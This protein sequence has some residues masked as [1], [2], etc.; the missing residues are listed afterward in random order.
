MV[1][2]VP[3][4]RPVL[5]VKAARE[6]REVP[7]AKGEPAAKGALVGE[8]APAAARVALAAAWDG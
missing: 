3:R 8:V 4:V 7:E 1:K 5:L 6:V 2:G